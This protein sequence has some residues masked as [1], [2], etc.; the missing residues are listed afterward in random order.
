MKGFDPA[1]WITV[2][3]KTGAITTAQT[4]DRESSYVKDGIYNITVLVVDN[5]VTSRFSL[6]YKGSLRL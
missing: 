1:G 3:E 4:L 2:D 5:G 6:F